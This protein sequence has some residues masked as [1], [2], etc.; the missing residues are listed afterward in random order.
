[1]SANPNLREST[2]ILVVD[3]IVENL[4]L[5]NTLLKNKNYHVAVAT[6]GEDALTIVHKFQPDLILLDI[7]MPGIDGFEVCRQ[8][9]SSHELKD[10]PVI[11]ISAK[12]DVADLA[13]GF[14]LGAVDYITKP[15]RQEEVFARIK[16]HLQL[17]QLNSDIIR[18][19]VVEKTLK[20][21]NDNVIEARDEALQASVTKSEFLAN[22]SHELRTPLNAIIGYTELLKDAIENDHD[23]SNNISDLD[24]IHVAS[25]H[26]LD[27]INGILD[28]SKIEAGRMDVCLTPIDIE[29]LLD[30]VHAAVA[31]QIKA[32]TIQF[33][34]QRDPSI[35]S[36][37][38]DEIK[39]RQTLI[40]LVSNAAKF[41]DHGEIELKVQKK[42]AQWIQFS[43]TDT[44]IGI[45]PDQMAK[46]FEPFTQADG[47]STRKYG[48][49]GLG[50]SISRRFA[51][52]M[53]GDITVSSV[54]D[55][56]STFTLTLP[57]HT[58]NE[59]DESQR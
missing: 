5:L 19:K 52:L 12:T 14:E 17:R 54:K 27:L 9:K 55:K 56:G 33:T 51:Q 8:L 47:S 46:L 15:I 1:M 42:E 13:R 16:T 57:I 30:N 11:F 7:M 21:L 48:G 6:S 24:K 53:G 49:T 32:K 10:I 3:D 20:R 38:A 40:N 22:M 2:K 26:L 35:S 44:G 50:L 31:P 25:H 59:S 45:A 29:Y 43:V 41:T 23:P 28:L 37:N 18:H 39:L 36:I 4:R 58:D 34:L